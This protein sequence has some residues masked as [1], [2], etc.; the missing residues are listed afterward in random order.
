MPIPWVSGSPPG[1]PVVYKG[2]ETMT[3]RKVRAK[4]GRKPGKTL[5]SVNVITGS[6]KAPAS[7]GEVAGHTSP[8]AIYHCWR[9]WRMSYVGPG[10]DAFIC[11]FCG[12]LNL[13]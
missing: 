8:G 7:K 9:C 1:I 3:K 13:V 4:K 6:K 12:A 11:P 5:S 10:Y 2:D